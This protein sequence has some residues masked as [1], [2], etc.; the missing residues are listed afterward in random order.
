MLTRTAR[1]ILSG[2]PGAPGEPDADAVAR[3]RARGRT[4]VPG[5]PLTAPLR[6]PHMPEK[7]RLM[8]RS[9]LACAWFAAAGGS[10]LAAQAAPGVWELQ[11]IELRASGRYRNP[12]VQVETWVDLKGPDFS[13]RV[14]GF[15]DGGDLFRVRFVATSPGE[16]R[17][18][19]GSNQPA[20]S[21]LNGRSGAFRAVSWT[22]A[23]KRE[24]PNRRGFLRPGGAVRSVAH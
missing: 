13:K 16:W 9:L 6:G 23:E 4:E 1:G 20:D 24:N 17:W 21:G 12:Y 3:S 15:W 18:T 8:L 14:Y 11:E 7:P 19:S 5:P 10:A 22:E 2:E